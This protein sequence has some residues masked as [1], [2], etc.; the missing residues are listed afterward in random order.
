MQKAFV[1]ITDESDYTEGRDE[2]RIDWKGFYKIKK[3]LS[4][5][6]EGFAAGIKVEILFTALAFAK[7]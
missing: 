4:T 3:L 5:C 6:N 1:R 2:Y 7:Q